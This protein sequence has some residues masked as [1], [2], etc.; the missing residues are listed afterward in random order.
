MRPWSSRATP[1]ATHSTVSSRNI[2]P[3]RAQAR[4]PKASAR[5]RARM[6][7]NQSQTS[8]ANS[9]R[10]MDSAM[11][12][13]YMEA[14]AARFKPR[15]FARADSVHF[16]AGGAHREAPF[17]MFGAQELREVLRRAAQRL[18]A[19]GTEPFE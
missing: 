5:S 12:P 6:L 10:V 19:F 13:F 2:R 15:A 14:A 16:R 9:S 8:A 17:G 1:S 4:L 7:S 3:S 11:S 18:A